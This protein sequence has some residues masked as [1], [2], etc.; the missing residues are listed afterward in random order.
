MAR[1]IK[2]TRI[3]NGRRQIYVFLERTVNGKKKRFWKT[4][5]TD[6]GSSK[7]IEVRRII[8]RSELRKELKEKFSPER[9]SLAIDKNVI[10][11]VYLEKWLLEVCEPRLAYRT[12]EDYKSH[13][14][15]YL[16]PFLTE[17][18]PDLRLKDLSPLK[19]HDLFSFM[20][21]AGKSY[22]VQKMKQVLSSA[23]SNA[24]NWELLE[25]NPVRKAKIEILEPAQR[26]I[27]S[28]LDAQKFLSVCDDLIIETYLLTGLRPSELAALR[29][30][31]I[32]LKNNKI[33]VVQ[34]LVRK[35]GGGFEFKQPKTKRSIR[36]IAV[37]VHLAEKLKL[38]KKAQINLIN[39][40]KKKNYLFENL[41]LVF[42]S[43]YGSPLH[44][45]NLNKR[46]LKRILS[47]AGLSEQ[48]S[49]YS[50]RHSIASLLLADGANVKD[51]QELLGHSSPS[52]TLN[53]Y[54]H[55]MPDSQSELAN[56]FQKIV[57]E[58]A[59]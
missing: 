15:K 9:R 55:S 42:C 5:Y 50:L 17:T 46:N 38:H 8:L 47:A 40:R 30:K 24:V 25:Y 22:A 21:S 14:K 23:C 54:I 20:R 26:K 3:R 58:S 49:L 48:I 41:D 56:R 4:E 39:Y 13:I 10:L 36:K 37:S 2:G 28:P 43:R 51:V 35:R 27:L 6:L 57:G 12:F 16:V 19:L 34:S 11:A 18:E 32:D 1:Q 31:D 7:E 29:W 53:K 45:N 44:I 33:S 59:D 52:F